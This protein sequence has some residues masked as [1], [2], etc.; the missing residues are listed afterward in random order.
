MTAA[1]LAVIDSH[2]S[3]TGTT[4]QVANLVMTSVDTPQVSSTASL[5]NKL[6]GDATLQV[7]VWVWVCVCMC[8]RACV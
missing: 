5:T 3:V 8:V 6:A 1:T 4:L 7:R 2:V